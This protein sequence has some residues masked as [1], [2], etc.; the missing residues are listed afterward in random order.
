MKE[1]KSDDNIKNEYYS[2]GEEMKD[3]RLTESSDGKKYDL[4]AAIA[5]SKQLGRPLTK[6]EMLRF[7]V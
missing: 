7:E 1:N 6:E 3:G 4:R 5:Y 2:F